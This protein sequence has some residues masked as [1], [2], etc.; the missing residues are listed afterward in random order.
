MYDMNLAED[1]CKSLPWVWVQR[2]TGLFFSVPCTSS[3]PMEIQLL[4][5]AFLVS[6][7]TI[8]FAY[9]HIMESQ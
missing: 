8:L 2:R 6:L 1:L 3:E 7:D 5:P 4:L 9:F